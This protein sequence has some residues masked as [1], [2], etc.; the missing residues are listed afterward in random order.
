M[1][2]ERMVGQLIKKG[3]YEDSAV[4][5]KDGLKEAREIIELETSIWEAGY[6][7]KRR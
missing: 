1:N 7:Q 3:K 6:G 5:K 4:F 2:K